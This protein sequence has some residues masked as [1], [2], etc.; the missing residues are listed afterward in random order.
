MKT[1]NPNRRDFLR[2]LAVL[3]LI[4]FATTA[5]AAKLAKES[6]LYQEMP[7]E[8]KVCRDCMHYLPETS[9]CKLVAGAIN[10]EGWCRLYV[11][12]PDKR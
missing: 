3:G 1:D 8:G 9:E 12:P 11:L 7:N 5:R 4:P 10:P 6:V 2:Y